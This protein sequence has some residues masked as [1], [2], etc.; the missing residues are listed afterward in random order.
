MKIIGLRDGKLGSIAS[1]AVVALVGSLHL[2]ILVKY[3]LLRLLAGEKWA[4]PV[5]INRL[6]LSGYVTYP[7]FV[8]AWISER[9]GWDILS[10]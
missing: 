6:S 1:L 5:R 7:L 3:L 9:L 10:Y 8:E 4:I 2:L